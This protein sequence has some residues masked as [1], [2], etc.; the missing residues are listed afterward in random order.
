MLNRFGLDDAGT[1]AFLRAVPSAAAL[2]DLSVAYFAD[3]DFDSHSDGPREALATLTRL[4]QRLGAVFDHWGGLDRV[5]DETAVVMTADHGHSV[6]G[7]DGEAAIDLD[8]LLSGYR[9]GNPATGWREGDELLVCPNMRSTEVF[10]HFDDDQRV[11]QLAAAMLRDERVDQV[12]WRQAYDDG[13]DRFHVMT[14]DRGSCT[15]RQAAQDGPAVVDEYGGRWELSGDEQALDLVVEGGR[16]RFGIYPN[17]LERIANGIANPNLGR[18]WVTARPGYE[19]AMAGQSVHKG[20]GSHGT[21]HEHDSRVP[22]LIAG[23]AKARPFSGTP[24]IVDVV[25]LCAGMLG[26]PFR[27]APGDGRC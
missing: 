26:I 6:V 9:R 27:W 7:G 2:P 14:A 25:P 16:V 17:A 4:D 13:R 3:Y 15:F 20:A 5:L 19:F 8:P 1:E 23:A 22:L 21:L 12:T 24:R 18:L 11:R 10:H